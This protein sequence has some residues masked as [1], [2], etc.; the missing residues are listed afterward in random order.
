MFICRNAI[1]FYNAFQHG[2]SAL[3]SSEQDHLDVIDELFSGITILFNSDA[4][5]DVLSKDHNHGA[6]YLDLQSRKIGSY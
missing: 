3:D 2:P 1:A 6:L 5:F 4:E